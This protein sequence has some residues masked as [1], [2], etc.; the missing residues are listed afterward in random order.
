MALKACLSSI[1]LFQYL[2]QRRYAPSSM[3]LFKDRNLRRPEWH[4]RVSYRYLIYFLLYI[5]SRT[6]Y[7]VSE[8]SCRHLSSIIQANSIIYLPFN[9]NY[10]KNYKKGILRVYGTRLQRA[11]LHAW[12]KWPRVDSYC[13]SNNAAHYESICWYNKRPLKRIL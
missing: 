6:R 9:Y 7:D 11:E 2:C 10:K 3:Y 8:S 13:S 5:M 12:V 1:T 4:Y